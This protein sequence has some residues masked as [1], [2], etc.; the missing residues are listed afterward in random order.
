MKSQETGNVMSHTAVL[1]AP[2]AP[3]KQTLTGHVSLLVVTELVLLLLM[4]FMPAFASLLTVV[5]VGMVAIDVLF[6]GGL[7]GGEGER[8]QVS[9]R[10][11]RKEMPIIA[12]Q[13]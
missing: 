6:F 11:N 9:K 1:Y 12:S 13:S 8:E 3:R 4:V 7:E 2:Y 5:E 10:G